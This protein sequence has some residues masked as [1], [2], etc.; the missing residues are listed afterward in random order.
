MKCGYGSTPAASTHPGKGCRA[1]GPGCRV[2]GAEFRVQGAGCRVHMGPVPC[3]LYPYLSVTV[4]DAP[5]AFFLIDSMPFMQA[6][7][8]L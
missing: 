1:Q 8:D 5:L 2:Q 7:L 6:S 3:A 4:T